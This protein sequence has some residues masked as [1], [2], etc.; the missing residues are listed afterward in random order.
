MT[1]ALTA[2]AE[3][4]RAFLA[5]VS[6]V[7]PELHRYCTRMTGSVFDAEDVVQDT[8]A[9]AYFAL[10][11]MESA[12][13]LRPWLFRIAHNA[14]MDFLRRAERRYVDATPDLDELAAAVDEP[15][16]DGDRIEAALH[17]FATL[18]PS[19]RSALAL[20][21]VLGLS[22]DE[23]AAAMG[24]TVAAVKGALV[25][26]R[27]N[28]ARARASG[29]SSEQRAELA[30][31]RHY[32]HLFNARDWDALRAL[33]T[34][35]TH[36]DLVSHHQRHGRS[37]A[38]YFTRYAAAAP[39]EDLRVEPGWV[40]GLPVLAMFRPAASLRPAYF[41][42]ITWQG[43]RVVRVRDFR[44]VPYIAAETTFT[45][46]AS[47]Q[48]I[49]RDEH[50]TLRFLVD[51]T[52]ERAVAAILDVRGWWS[53]AL[54]GNSAKPGDEFTYR[55]GDLHRSTQRVTEVV[56]GARVVWRVLDAHLS[57]AKN[58]A[59]WTGT[60]IVFEVTP[61]DGRTE[62]R[63]THVGLVPAVECFAMCAKGWRYY[64]GESLQRLLT[65]GTGCPD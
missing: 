19:Q 13:P 49:M 6:E 44:Q 64:V 50:F 55:H 48:E 62:V 23:T 42:R 36:L 31:L 18:P 30:R 7:R 52:P 38:E 24:T 46:A 14:A 2:M 41:I 35:E 43:E 3:A 25:R 57:F 59:E 12:P 51:E 60:D 65:T 17:V 11:E 45:A 32:A 4:R 21:D 1:D 53:R 34:D 58:P 26:A 37:A 16:G 28:V 54:E 8:L 5:M 63:F 61:R 20:K 22:L 33:F 9:R 29:P 56:P 40:E 15:T 10:C 39:V 27:A 47:E